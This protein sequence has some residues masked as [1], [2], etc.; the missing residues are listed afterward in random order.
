VPLGRVASISGRGMG[1]AGW[2][3]VWSA[4]PGQPI[5]KA[6]AAGLGIY[7]AKTVGADVTSVTL[8]REQLSISN[9]RAAREGLQRTVRFRLEDRGDPGLPRP[10]PRRV[11]M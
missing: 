3:A 10:G 5:D 9:Q 8:S 2:V 6:H 1:P 11:S 7:L 4:L